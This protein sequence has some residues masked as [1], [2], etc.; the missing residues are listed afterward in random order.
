ME[1]E[2][3]K[4]FQE[5]AT[6]LCEE[7]PKINLAMFYIDTMERLNLAISV[8]PMKVRANYCKLIARYEKEMTALAEEEAKE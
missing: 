6:K 2:R 1:S 3:F 8:M 5:M 7:Q 4:A